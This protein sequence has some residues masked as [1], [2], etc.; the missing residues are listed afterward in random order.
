M[1]NWSTL[2]ELQHSIL[3]T[4]LCEQPTE[5]GSSIVSWDTITVDPE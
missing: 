1:M 4:Y 2:M 3:C 5:V